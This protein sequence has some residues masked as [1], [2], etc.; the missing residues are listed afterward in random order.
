MGLTET[1]SDEWH[2]KMMGQPGIQ[3]Y[4][5]SRT[6]R[7]L[8]Q[9]GIVIYIYYPLGAS[10][11]SIKWEKSGSCLVAVT[12]ESH[13]SKQNFSRSNLLYLYQIFSY[14]YYVSDIRTCWSV[15]LSVRSTF[16]QP[17]TAGL[18]EF[19]WTGYYHDISSVL[20]P[21]KKL[22]SLFHTFYL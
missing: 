17:R 7:K 14:L 5:L 16:C 20:L 8:Y 6:R 22:Y 3:T 18:T 12:E 1:Y 4:N 15:N 11:L 19:V 13:Q 10:H 21:S 9:L 2:M